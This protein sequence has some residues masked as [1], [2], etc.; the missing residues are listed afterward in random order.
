LVVLGVVEFLVD[1]VPAADTV[2]DIIQ[3]FI[4]PTAGAILFAAS[5]NVVTDLSTVLS[6]ILGLLV[7]G[8]VHATKTTVR[9]MVTATTGGIG[10]PVVS[11]VEDIV[12]TTLALLAVVL[13]WLV[14]LVAV[15]GIVLFLAWRMRRAQARNP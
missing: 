3:T 2:N 12:S 4:R 1:K 9:P 7:A 11:T 8:G 15:V 5:A 13:P 14:L 6:L 10:N